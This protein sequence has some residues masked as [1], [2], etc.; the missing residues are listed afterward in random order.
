MQQ[1]KQ[2]AGN[3]LVNFRLD[4]SDF[5]PDESLAHAED[6]IHFHFAIDDQIAALQ[7]IVGNGDSVI[8]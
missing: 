4:S 3:S 1:L 2:H 7:L 6:P 8:S 5:H